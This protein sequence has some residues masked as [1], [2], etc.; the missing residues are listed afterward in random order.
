MK[1]ISLLTKD[2][3]PVHITKVFHPAGRAAAKPFVGLTAE[4]GT[5]LFTKGEEVVWKRDEALAEVSA[6]LCVDLP[7]DAK[8]GDRVDASHKQ[9]GIMDQIQSQILNLKV[10]T[11][12]ASCA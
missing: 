6:A 2:G 4:D 3:A 7:A 8:A 9:T 10:S 1:G 12:I 11:N 5:V